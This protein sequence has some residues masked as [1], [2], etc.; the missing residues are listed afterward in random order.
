MIEVVL[1]VIAVAVGVGIVMRM[2]V[3]PRQAVTP[4]PAGE[5]AAADAAILPVDAAILPAET[6]K[7]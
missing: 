2:D 3:E 5:P 1:L 6:A 7:D 4:D